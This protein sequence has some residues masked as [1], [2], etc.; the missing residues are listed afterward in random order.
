MAVR[1]GSVAIDDRRAAWIGGG[2]S[3]GK[4]MS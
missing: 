3:V 1:P 4:L 2:V